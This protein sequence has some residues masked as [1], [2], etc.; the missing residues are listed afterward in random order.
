[1]GVVLQK[2]LGGGPLVELDHSFQCC[3]DEV[4][5]SSS[6]DSWHTHASH[7]IHTARDKKENVANTKDPCQE[8]SS[9]AV[10]QA[11]LES[12]SDGMDGR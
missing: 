6:S 1:M 7:H 3:N 2:L 9:S 10:E 5:S 12:R 8:P 11:A 4:H